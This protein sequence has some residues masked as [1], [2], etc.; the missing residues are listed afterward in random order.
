MKKEPKIVG[1]EWVSSQSFENEIQRRRLVPVYRYFNL[2]GLDCFV[3]YEE[4]LGLF[5]VTEKQT[6][7]LVHQEKV[8]VNNSFEKTAQFLTVKTDEAIWNAVKKGLDLEK[9]SWENY[10]LI[11]TN[12]LLLWNQM[13]ILPMN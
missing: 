13:Q 2:R 3:N 10:N 9:Q 11:L 12:Q 8:T 5:R 4:R 7:F 6:G 1:Y